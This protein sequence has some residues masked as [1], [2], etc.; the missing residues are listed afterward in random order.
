V[1]LLPT[2]GLVGA[3]VTSLLAYSSSAAYMVWFARRRL[4]IGLIE[5]LVPRPADA[6]QWVR[7]LRR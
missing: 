5:L 4:E 3:A 7:C 1:I 2:L 6:V